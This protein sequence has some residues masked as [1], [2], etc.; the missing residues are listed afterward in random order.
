MFVYYPIF[1]DPIF[2]GPIPPLLSFDNE[3]I[4]EHLNKIE[5]ELNKL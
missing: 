2:N 4:T 3:A 1:N 5:E